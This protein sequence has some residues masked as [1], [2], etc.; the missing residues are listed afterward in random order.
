MTRREELLKGADMTT[1]KKQKQTVELYWCYSLLPNPIT[2]QPQEN[3]LI[4]YEIV[5]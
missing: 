2:V 5:I 4:N 1:D 3:F